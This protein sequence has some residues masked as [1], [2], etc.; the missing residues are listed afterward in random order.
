MQRMAKPLPLADLFPALRR[1]LERDFESL[2]P[3]LQLK[4][5]S[6]NHEVEAECV[7]RARI[8]WQSQGIRECT[9]GCVGML[10]NA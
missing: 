4:V 3:C 6:S 8:R 10:K 2:S 9:P 5:A 7:G 1:G